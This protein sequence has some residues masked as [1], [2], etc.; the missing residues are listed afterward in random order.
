MSDYLNIS[1]VAALLRLG[2]RTVYELARTGRL[3]GAAKVANKWRFN[4]T[5]LVAWLDAGGQAQLPRPR[6]GKGGT[7]ER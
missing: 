3:P 2:E 1:E 4:R 5:K 7:R 6:Q